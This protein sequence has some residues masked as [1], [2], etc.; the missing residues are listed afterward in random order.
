MKELALIG[1]T[2]SGKTALALRIAKPLNAIILSLDSLC[3][4]TQINIAS[5]KPNAQELKSIKHFGINIRNIDESFNAGDFAQ[6]YQKAS[7][8]AKQNG[9]NLIITGG[10]GFYLASM[11]NGL[12][13]KVPR[14][15]THPSNDE[16]FTIASRIDPKFCAKFSHNDTFRLQKWY[17]IYSFLSKN[18]AQIKISNNLTKH[19]QI[20]SLWLAQNTAAPLIKELLI[21]ELSL[22]RDELRS[23]ILARTKKM[24]DDGLLDEARTLFASYDKEL[25]ALKSIGLKECGQFL[26]G[27]IKSQNELCELISTHTAQLAK[28]QR[29]FFNSNFKNSIKLK[30]DEAYTQILNKLL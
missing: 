27:Q 2:A 17:E 30:P 9:K 11:L 26:C 14:L 29:S 7:I 19:T 22:E 12:A 28:R 18:S 20:P 8:Y 10:S 16:I 4:Y 1:A 3:I 13:P 24:L 6:E 5:A 23:R 25:K 15:K 21:F